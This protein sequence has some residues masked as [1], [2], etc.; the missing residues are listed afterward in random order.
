MELFLAGAASFLALSGAVA[1]VWDDEVREAALTLLWA[2]LTLPAI[3][4]WAGAM[5][6]LSRLPDHVR[7]RMIRGRGLSV[8]ALRRVA[9]RAEHDGWMVS[10]RRA[11]IIVM[12]KVK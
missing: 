5:T 11:S 1:I 3:L 12:R 4:L 7:P 10:S 2:T 6:L 9:E 8:H